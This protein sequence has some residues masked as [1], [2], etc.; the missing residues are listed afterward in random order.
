MEMG[1][2]GQTEAGSEREGEEGEK[3]RDGGR[4]RGGDGE[5]EGVGEKDRDGGGGGEGGDRVRENIASSKH[6][7]GQK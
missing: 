7:T 1:R 5:R 2:D 6:F 4:A 3:Q